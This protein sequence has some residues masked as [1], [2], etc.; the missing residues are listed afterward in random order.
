M[1]WICRLSIVVAV[2]AAVVGMTG[3]AML[4]R[5]GVSA[6]AE[7]S[8]LESAFAR[9]VRH[10]AIPSAARA[11]NNPER[12]TPEALRDGRAHFA[13]HCAQCHGN[14]GAGGTRIGRSLSPRTP[15]MRLPATQDLSDGEL[16]WI[17]ENGVR[18]TGMPAW[19]EPGSERASWHLVHFIRH[20]PNLTSEEKQEMEGLNPKSPDEWRELEEENAFL[21]GDSAPPRRDGSHQK[22][23]PAD[24][25]GHGERER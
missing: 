11:M 20:L 9:R 13:D 8:E 15:D 10:W 5:S 23:A 4:L 21:R 7:P 19:G 25:H 2:L 17:I 22:S 16:F 3:G 14:N 18:L 6:R 24:A 12:A 1:R